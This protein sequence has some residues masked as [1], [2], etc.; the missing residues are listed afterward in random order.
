MNSRALD[1]TALVIA[2][3]GAVNW[4][5]IGFFRFN[6]VTFLFGEDVYKRQAVL[7]QSD[8]RC[9]RQWLRSTVIS[10]KC[11]FY[12][13]EF[14]IK[15]VSYT[16]LDVYKR[17]KEI[18]L[19]VIMGNTC[20][21][22]EWDIAQGKMRGAMKRCDRQQTNCLLYTSKL[23][24]FFKIRYKKIGTP[25]KAVKIPIGISL[26]DKSLAQL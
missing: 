25:T 18:I 16:H 9:L 20:C 8:F 14:S 1:Y 19:S 7:G 6:L 11:I 23:L 13:R 12:L 3:I 17:Q 10:D 26:V 15:P 2:L 5:L 4:G 21:W 22:E 24:S